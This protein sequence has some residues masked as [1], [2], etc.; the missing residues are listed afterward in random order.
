MCEKKSGT[1]SSHQ[2]ALYEIF[3]LDGHL[4]KAFL[5]Q[6]LP[7]FLSNAVNNTDLGLKNA[8]VFLVELYETLLNHRPLAVKSLTAT[9]MGKRLNWLCFLKRFGFDFDLL[10][11]ID[12]SGCFRMYP[13]DI[14][15]IYP[16][17]IHHINHDNMM[18]I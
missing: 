9:R 12:V 13:S 2:D 18:D 16:Y 14:H 6:Y 3:L 8:L 15:H 17:Y 5:F 11:F 4:Q 10:I 1:V 7:L